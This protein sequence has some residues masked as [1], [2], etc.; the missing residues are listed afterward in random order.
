MTEMGTHTR[1]YRHAGTGTSAGTGTRNRNYPWPLLLIAAPA[2]VAVWSGWVGLGSMCGFGPV[3]L[4][5]GIGSG[6]RLNTAITLPVGIECYGAYALSAWLT[7]KVASK[8][9]RDFARKSAIGALVLGCLGQVAY[10]LLAA[11]GWAEAPWPVTML[12]ACL[13]VVTLYF[14]AALSHL[15]VADVREAREARVATELAAAGAEQAKAERAA[16]RAEAAA[17]R[18]AQEDPGTGT[19]KRNR[20][21]SRTGTRNQPEPVPAPDAEPDEAVDLD[22]EARI[23]DALGD[24]TMDTEKGILALVAAGHTPSKAG[25]LAGK[26]DS[27]GRKVVRMARD[28]AKAAPKGQDSQE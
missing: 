13:P 19:P 3:N 15:I 17:Q 25:L 23:L 8:K 22:A 20:N 5:P 14:G 9:T 7:L 26:S 2:V 1:N 16:A 6:F 11:A 28:L 12:V 27:Y 10:H 4:L 24:G 18:A 21:Q